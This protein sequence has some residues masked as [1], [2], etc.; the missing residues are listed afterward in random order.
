MS[1][2]S[3]KKLPTRNLIKLIHRVDARLAALTNLSSRRR[4]PS[5]AGSMRRSYSPK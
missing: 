5:R 3:L 1:Q 4:K 2:A